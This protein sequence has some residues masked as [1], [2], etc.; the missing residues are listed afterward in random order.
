MG[1]VV[2]IAVLLAGLLAIGGLVGVVVML[3][4]GKR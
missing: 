3:I 4:R 2:I 1:L